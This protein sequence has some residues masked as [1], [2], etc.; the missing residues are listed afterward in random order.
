MH[1][2]TK[3]L[4]VVLAL[5]TGGA[6]TAPSIA[7]VEEDQ[8]LR[9]F[10]QAELRRFARKMQQRQESR[11]TEFGFAEAFSVSPPA[12]APALEIADAA[13]PAEPGRW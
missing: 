12:A 8:G 2:L 9:A 6:C 5:G 1:I 4:I 7:A 10:S 3:A 13:A 11:R